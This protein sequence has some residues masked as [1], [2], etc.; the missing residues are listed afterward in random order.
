VLSGFKNKVSHLFSKLFASKDLPAGVKIILWYTVILAVF[1]F[2]IGVMVPISYPGILSFNPMVSLFNFVFLLVSGVIFYGILKR[3]YWAYKLII[4]WYVATIVYN[5]LY[6]FYSF[7]IFDVMSD[8]LLTGLVFSFVVNCVVIWYL[9]SQKDYFKHSGVFLLHRRIRLKM[10]EAHDHIF[11]VVF[12]SC[13]FVTILVL[14]F[15]GT[16]LINTT[17][18]MS[19]DVISK[20]ESTGFYD[21]SI[22]KQKDQI[23]SDVCY[24]NFGIITKDNSYCNS[25]KSAFYKF[26]CFVG[27]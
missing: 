10:V 15:A 2:L 12:L 14:L 20:V 6:F 7:D 19:K 4:I 23:Y 18:A 3:K 26:T 16:K 5:F 8:V 1:Q 27:A 13:W 22:C 17:F 24:M 9:L 11:M 21:V 25:V